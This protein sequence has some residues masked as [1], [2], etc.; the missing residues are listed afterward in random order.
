WASRHLPT[1]FE[2]SG[3]SAIAG[4]VADASV[5]A[6]V[7]FFE[8]N[9]EEAA[10]MLADNELFEPLLLACELAS[11]CR[12]KIRQFPEQRDGLIQA[13]GMALAT[14]YVWSAVDQTEV[15][16]LALNAGLSTYDASY[17]HLAYSLNVPLL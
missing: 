17:L 8:P 14:D 11:I 6:A 16:S 1:Q 10:A 13:L 4:R 7:V 9:A 12:I 15:V 3:G 5:V 2:S